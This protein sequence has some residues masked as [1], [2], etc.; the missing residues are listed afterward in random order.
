[1]HP[2]Q[3]G[4]GQPHMKSFS[5][6]EDA[7]KEF[8]QKFSDK[9]KNKWEDKGHFVAVPDKYILL[10]MD[11]TKDVSIRVV[12]YN[13]N[14]HLGHACVGMKTGHAYNSVYTT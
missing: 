2:I 5:S 4:K 13:S 14:G 7:E 11:A 9:T 3:G 8:K 6:L 10:E 12:W 1:M